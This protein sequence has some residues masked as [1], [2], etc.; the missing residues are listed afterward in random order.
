MHSLARRRSRAG[1]LLLALTLVVSKPVRADTFG[2]D[3]LAKLD[4]WEGQWQVQIQYDK[5][6]YSHAGTSSYSGYCSWLTNH[7]FMLCDFLSGKPVP[8]TGKPDNAI[9]IL[10]YSAPDK[11]YKHI[12][13][14][15]D[16]VPAMQST[17][18]VDGNV[19]TIPFELPYK[20]KTLLGRD[21]YNFVSPDKWL[22]RFEMSSDNG[23]HWIPVMQQEGE[24]VH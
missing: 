2:A 21:I 8:E 23:E 17:M 3:P 5:S 15:Q 11:A 16:L 1:I 18:T 10:S 9:V 14:G 19:W 6:P 20:G 22:F 13:M 12:E 7:G 4:V 24:K